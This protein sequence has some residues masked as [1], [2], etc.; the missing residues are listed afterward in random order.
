MFSVNESVVAENA[1]GSWSGKIKKVLDDG[2]YEV[3][4]PYNG[5][6]G[7]YY[8]V[9]HESQITSFGDDLFIG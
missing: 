4:I 8:A 9:F 6:F 1:H 5:N 2:Y 3:Y 7:N